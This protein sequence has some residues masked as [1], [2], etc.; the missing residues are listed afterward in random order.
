MCVTDKHV[1]ST[2]HCIDHEIIERLEWREL[3]YSVK[4]AKTN[5]PIN[6]TRPTAIMARKNLAMR[7]RHRLKLKTGPG[8][9][10][11]PR[12]RNR[13]SLCGKPLGV[14]EL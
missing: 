12:P 2:I 4:A 10:R 1:A 6:M 7:T 9:S 8:V 14:Y 5:A 3:A 11:R 13:N